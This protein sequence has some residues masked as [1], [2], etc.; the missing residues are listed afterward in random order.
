[1]KGQKRKTISD[2]VQEESEH[3]RVTRIKIAEFQ[4]KEKTACDKVK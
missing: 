4:A 1:M 3:I 2:M